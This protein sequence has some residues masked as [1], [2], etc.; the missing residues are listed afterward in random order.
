MPAP[1]HSV[2]LQAGCP[3]CR[4][5]N[6]VKALKAPSPYKKYFHQINRGDMQFPLQIKDIPKLEKLNNL[7]INVFGYSHENNI[8]CF[9]PLDLSENVQPVGC[10]T[11]FRVSTSRVLH[12]FLHGVIKGATWATPYICV[13]PIGT[14]IATS[15]HVSYKNPDSLQCVGWMRTSTW[16]I[17]PHPPS[18]ASYPTPLPQIQL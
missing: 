9:Y 1:H 3:S 13:H 6:S 10:T 11:L 17:P 16:D 12:V 8:E 4:P 5:T 14:A 18:P 2:F 7:A 15:P